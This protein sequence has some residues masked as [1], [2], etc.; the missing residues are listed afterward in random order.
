MTTHR[1]SAG[2]PSGGQFAAGARD[3]VDL[4][5]TASLGSTSE[6]DQETPH[7]VY[8]FSAD[9][10][11]EA[12]ASIEKANR[13][14]EKAGIEER[15]GYTVEEFTETV[16]DAGTG[17]EV[18]N[19]R[20]RLT[21]DRP[22]IRHEGWEFIGT[23]NWDPYAGLVSRMV[24]GHSLGE[25]EIDKRCD[26]CGAARERRDT[27]VVQQTNP[28]TGEVERLQVGSDCLKRFTGIRPAGLFLL[29]FDLDG[30]NGDD[31]HEPG[32]REPAAVY[33]AGDVLAVT[34]AVVKDRGW[35]PR[36]RAGDG[37]EATAGVVMRVFDSRG[38]GA[39]E[40]EVL[41]EYADEARGQV[42]AAA[43][44]LAMAREMDGD[45]DY[46]IDL[47]AVA[48]GE[49]VSARNVALLASAV[50]S[51]QRHKA[52]QAD[53][54]AQADSTF[55]GRPKDK[56]AD[57]RVTVTG[58]RHLPGDYGTKTLVLMRDTEGNVLKWFAS[59]YREFAPGNDM[60]LKATIKGHEEY[61]GVKQTVITR[62][63][64]TPATVQSP[65]GVGTVA[66]AKVAKP[67]RVVPSA[68]PSHRFGTVHSV[69]GVNKR[70][71][72]LTEKYLDDAGEVH[73]MH[74]YIYDTLA[75]QR[76]TR[77]AEIAA[78]DADGDKS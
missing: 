46:A 54:A 74:R 71:A 25:R 48:N 53:A 29:D 13:R 73:E 45:S 67:R 55:I 72:T 69:N 14:A 32:A 34:L 36:S 47:R 16:R 51:Y 18:H 17:V 76:D 1:V 42:D 38:A 63:D 3:E 31:D 56:I 50:S 28:E 12:V 27:Y 39:R 57:R 59:D 77:L 6:A 5:L 35:V 10:L 8:T 43:E 4:N 33:Q 75:A 66:S 65:T 52:Q 40:K 30:F 37:Q 20:V 19:P 24:P 70:F 78:F 22:S 7:P 58:V 62:A 9:R 61:Q 15:I 2:V 60:V 64:L 23:L 49:F 44:V 11:S 21:L 68:N 41:R 26:V